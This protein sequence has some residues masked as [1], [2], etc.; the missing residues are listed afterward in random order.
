MFYF[1][2]VSADRGR[3]CDRSSCDRDM[4]LRSRRCVQFRSTF[5]T[6]L[7]SRVRLIGFFFTNG[8]VL[9]IPILWISKICFP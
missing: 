6:A 7:V 1:M 4:E 9:P 3:A 8:F 5:S 2:Y